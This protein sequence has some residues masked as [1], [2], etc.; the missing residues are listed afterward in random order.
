MEYTPALSLANNEF[1]SLF[2]VYHLPFLIW[3]QH[4]P[5]TLGPMSKILP[6]TTPEPSRLASE[7][8][9][10]ESVCHLQNLADGT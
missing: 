6:V 5:Y 4:L 2:W 7:A 9:F 1:V 10:F 8:L 3:M